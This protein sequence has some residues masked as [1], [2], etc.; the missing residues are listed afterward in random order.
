MS[1]TLS[2]AFITQQL[3]ELCAQNGVRCLFSV[4]SGSRAWG[5]A[6]PDSDYDVR[7][8]YIRPTADYLRI[9][10]QRDVIEHMDT[11]NN[12]DMVGW[13]ATKALSLIGKSNPSAIEWLHTPLLYFAEDQALDI[14]K[15]AAEQCYTP[16]ALSMHYI[17]LGYDHVKKYITNKQVIAPK[18]Y[19]Y[20][21]RSVL[22]AQYV[23]AHHRP[24]PIVFAELL[25]QSDLPHDMQSIIDD[26]LVIKGREG[27]KQ[28][29]EQIAPLN[30]YLTSSLDDLRHKAAS[31]S[32]N[33]MDS[34]AVIEEAFQE[35]L[36][37]YG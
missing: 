16:K 1:T 2:S 23:I 24:A 21:L 14:L 6:S 34:A 27:E 25:Q 5:F 36:K 4:E 29:I 22:S 37:V 12:L 15:A 13:D 18:K 17:S 32:S 8:I 33:R 3:Q 20:A 10:R 31:L 19:F 11:P 9:Q 28:Q 30:N 26:L 7:F 35:L